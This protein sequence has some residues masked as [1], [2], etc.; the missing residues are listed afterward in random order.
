MKEPTFLLEMY[1]IKVQ[2]LLKPWKNLSQKRSQM[3]IYPSYFS[4]HLG[5]Q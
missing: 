2:F 1:H 5:S 4:L 3:S